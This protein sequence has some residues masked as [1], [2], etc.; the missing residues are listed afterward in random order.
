MSIHTFGPRPI[1]RLIPAMLM[2]VGASIACLMGHAAHA[3][4]LPC[5]DQI[6]P[7]S[8]VLST[9]FGFNAGN[10]RMQASSSIDA[11]NVASLRPAYVHVAEGA[12]E[13]RSAPAVTAQTV[14]FSEGREIVAANRATGCEYWRYKGLANKSSVMYGSNMVRSSSLYYLAPTLLH[15]PLVFAG[16]AQG[17]LYALNAQ[18]GQEVWRAFMGTDANRHTLTGSVQYGGGTLFVPVATKEVAMTMFDFFTACCFTHGMLQ[19]LD[20]YTGR[21]KWTYHTAPEPQLDPKTG[22]RGPSGMSIW[23][24]PAIDV[25]NN[26]VLIGTGQNMS[27]PTTPNSDAVISL[28][29]FTGKVRWVYQTTADD[30]WNMACQAPLGLNAHCPKAEGGDFDIGAP[31]IVANLPGGG[32]AVLAGAK[33][34]VV[35][36]LD[37]RSGTLNWA[38]RVGVGGNLGGIHWGMAA[39]SQRVY[40]AVTDVWVNKLQRL[41]INEL[42]G[43]TG[44]GVQLMS[45]VEGARPGIY[46]LDLLTGKVVWEKHDQHVHEG[47]TYNSLFSAALSLS[48]DVLF[49]G[50][51]D[52]QLKALRS[53]DG[54]ELWAFDTTV[55]VAD[56]NGVAGKGGTIDSSGPVPAGRDLLINSGY[57]T[58]GGTNAWQ[59]GPG[60][61]L[62]VFRLP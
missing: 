32:K 22:T 44:N 29:M 58:F 60:N 12:K 34:G 28:D 4:T 57:N 52:G 23:G 18:T 30:A 47:Q 37:P 51:L 36:S 9:G 13:K 48:H 33:S 2:A 40:A 46:A 38:T 55:A 8:P 27:L 26:A 15:A 6:N 25:A 31:P 1:Q 42:L 49:T 39:D 43:L 14:Y 41:A 11:A 54:A 21:I 61:V 19:A 53:S 5:T 10:T 59:A 35:Y 17:I 24:T 56:V 50:S 16:D 62:F 3:A 20:P 7:W 45:P